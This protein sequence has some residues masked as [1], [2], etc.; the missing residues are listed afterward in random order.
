[1]AGYFKNLFGET[2]EECVEKC[3]GCEGMRGMRQQLVL[4]EYSVKVLSEQFELRVGNLEEGEY[5]SGFR[6]KNCGIRE[7][8]VCLRGVREK[9]SGIGEGYE[10]Y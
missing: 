3:E 1:M 6:K 5:V 10:G 2:S 7:E 8:C 9:D 4:L